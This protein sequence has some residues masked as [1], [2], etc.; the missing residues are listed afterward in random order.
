MKKKKIF[1]TLA[2]STL[3]ISGG[4]AFADETTPV[5]PTIPTTEIVTSTESSPTTPVETPTETTQPVETPTDPTIPTETVETEVPT[6]PVDPTISTIPDSGIIGE[7]NTSPETTQPVETPTDPKSG[8]DTEPSTSEEPKTELPSSELPQTAEQAIKEGKPQ[9]GTTSV[10]TGQVVQSVTPEAPINTYTG[11]SI[12]STQA[13]QLV[14]S[15]GSTVAP[16][17]I[18]AVSN[19]D[20]T[21]TVTKA[22]G[23]KATLP[24]TGDSES[25]LG[26]L[27]FL[28]TAISA[29]FWKKRHQA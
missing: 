20:K 9:E 4:V 3:I 14:L 21:I 17:V 1:A 16:E 10:V 7:G 23:T 26:L 29:F 27:G 13:G 6:P 15:D 12:V 8:E 2:T 18:G 22:D 11:A 19:A 25:A 28:L 5:D 24:H